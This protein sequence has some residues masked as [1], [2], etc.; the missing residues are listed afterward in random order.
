MEPLLKTYFNSFSIV[1]SSIIANVSVTA[2]AAVASTKPL[3]IAA[4]AG[5][6]L[7]SRDNNDRNTHQS[8]T[9]GQQN[10]TSNSKYLS[11]GAFKARASL[12][13]ASLSH[14]QQ[15]Q[16]QQQ[17]QPPH[18]QPTVVRESTFLLSAGGGGGGI[19]E[20]NSS[21]TNNFENSM[22]T[23]GGDNSISKESY[24]EEELTN[25]FEEYLK[26]SYDQSTDQITGSSLKKSQLLKR[27][28]INVQPPSSS[29][30][31]KYRSQSFGLLSLTNNEGKSC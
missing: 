20:S 7:S 24:N 15:Q 14:Q 30:S 2:S 1:R 26:L 8:P 21:T 19:N 9:Q 28:S 31:Y 25:S 10:S 17:Q 6:S 3:S 27:P 12:A 23:V 16:Q 4:S 5:N 13:F 18:R 22:S 11:R 29:S